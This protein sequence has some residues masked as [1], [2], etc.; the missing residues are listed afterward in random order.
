MSTFVP[1]SSRLRL[2]LRRAE[3]DLLPARWLSV[4]DSNCAPEDVKK[5]RLHHHLEEL[6]V[7]ADELEEAYIKSITTSEGYSNH[8]GK[9]AIKAYKSF[10]KQ[11]AG[12]DI[13][14]A[15]NRFARQIDFLAKRH[16]SKEAEY[17]RHLDTAETRVSFP[18]VLV[19]DNLRSAANV[20]SI[21]RSADACGCS[22]VLTT[23]ITPHPN[24]NG[25]EKLSKSSLGAERVVPSRHFSTTLHAVEWL[26]RGRPNFRLIGMETT[27]HSKTYTNV[28]YPGRPGPRI[29]QENDGGEVPTK[30]SPG[31][32]LF[33]G[34]EVSGVDTEIFPLLDEMIEIPMFGLKNSLN[35]A[36]CAPVVMYEILRQWEV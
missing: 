18:L 5:S 3:C 30:N 7:R 25:A 17:V 34:N 31:V 27:E 28:S 11:K 13:D 35:V 19:L 33:L 21:F 9:P 29:A 26:R 8:F 10:F 1:L 23:G 20:G 16:R 12:E 15:A 2:C 14:V 24:G 6:G 36:A 32:A 22:E 4:R